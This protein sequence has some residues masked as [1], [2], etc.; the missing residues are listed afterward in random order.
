MPILTIVGTVLVA[1]AT[2]GTP[3]RLCPAYRTAGPSAQPNSS[4]LFNPSPG[5]YHAGQFAY[6]SDWPSTPSYYQGGQFIWFQE[7]LYDLQGRGQNP[8]WTYRRFETYRSGF[9]FR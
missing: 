4:I 9:G 1:A 5:A 7:R 3:Y 6:R 8:N 2:G